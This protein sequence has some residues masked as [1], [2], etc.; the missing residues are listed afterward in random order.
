MNTPLTD[1]E[2]MLATVKSAAADIHRAFA[3]F[4]AKSA[5]NKVKLAP[6]HALASALVREAEGALGLP[7]GGIMPLDGTS[8]PPA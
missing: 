7:M 8:K 6:A 5:T 3:Y 2:L 1:D 4:E